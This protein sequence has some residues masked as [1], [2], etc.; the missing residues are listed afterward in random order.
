MAINRFR[1]LQIALLITAIALGLVSMGALVLRPASTGSLRTFLNIGC[2]LLV[3]SSSTL[4]AVRSRR[5]A[6]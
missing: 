5:R 1:R 2:L 4:A 6:A 3:L